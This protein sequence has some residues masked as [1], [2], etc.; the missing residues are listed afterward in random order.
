[1]AYE[2]CR[3]A[4]LKD[5]RFLEWT[6]NP[7]RVQAGKTYSYQDFLNTNIPAGQIVKDAQDGIESMKKAIMEDEL[8]EVRNEAARSYK[9]KTDA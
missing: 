1:M 5:S 7:I 4:L 6:A 2:E 9:Q 3:D 8:A